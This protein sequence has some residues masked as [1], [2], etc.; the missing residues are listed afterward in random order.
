MENG[1]HSVFDL[2]CFTID[3]FQII[4]C[5]SVDPSKLPNIIWRF[6]KYCCTLSLN[7]VREAQYIEQSNMYSAASQHMSIS[8]ST[9]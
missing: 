1:T 5:L 9:R 2:L 6:M 7:C 8:I 3:Y 4:E